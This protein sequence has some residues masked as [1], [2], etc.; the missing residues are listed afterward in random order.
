MDASQQPNSFTHTSA[1]GVVHNRPTDAGYPVDVYGAFASSSAANNVG[2]RPSYNSN[3]GYAIQDGYYL[4]PAPASNSSDTR[5]SNHARAEHTPF[6]QQRDR[7]QP[8][9]DAG[10][11][12]HAPAAPSPMAGDPQMPMAG[13]P[14]ILHANP[15]VNQHLYA[16]Y[17]YAAFDQST[18][19]YAP[20]RPPRRE[21]GPG[22]SHAKSEK[23]S[24]VSSDD[25]PPNSFLHRVIDTLRSATL[26]EVVPI[27]TLF[28]AALVHH[29]R[30]RRSDRLVPY[31]AQPWV[32][33]AKNAV[34][35]YNCYGFAKNNNFFK[36]R[37][38]SIT[39]TA[40]S[41]DV[42]GTRDLQADS[43]DW[44]APGLLHSIVSSLFRSKS[45]MDLPKSSNSL[46]DDFDSSWAVPR[47]IAEN[48]YN[49]VYRDSASLHNAKAVILGGAAA[50][51]ALYEFN[52]PANQRMRDDEPANTQEHLVLGMALAEVNH[53]LACKAESAVLNDDDTLE[54]VGKIAL[55]TI[56]KIKIDEERA[57]QTVTTEKRGANWR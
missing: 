20:P 16:D 1:P 37:Q 46:V 32:K 41:L 31:Q 44:M 12:P 55:A 42:D 6:N 47:L 5:L 19:H 3:P 11:Y 28:G 45:A 17:P 51:K 26:S 34:F 57:Y 43:G 22:P 30:H 2:L 48:Y 53:L 50:I 49:Y 54:T 24:T 23:Q 18:S 40:R 4:P 35:A 56:I 33:H 29:F 52:A 15:P 13:N 25:G 36:P 27:A 10:Q 9:F 14:Q 21:N 39:S 8:T 38:R 7:P